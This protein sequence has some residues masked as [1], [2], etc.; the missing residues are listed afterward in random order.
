MSLIFLY[1]PDISR[2][3]Q[4]IIKIDEYLIVVEGGITYLYLCSSGVFGLSSTSRFSSFYDPPPSLFW[5]FLSSSLSSR[6]FYLPFFYF[7]FLFD[8]IVYVFKLYLKML[9]WEFKIFYKIIINLLLLKK[10]KKLNFFRILIK[11]YIFIFL[12][13]FIFS[14]FHFFVIFHFFIFSFFCYFSFFQNL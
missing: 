12:L 3:S 11:I 6:D 4:P 5:L 1:F 9:I 13:F 10:Y 7:F 8:I 2:I 14:F